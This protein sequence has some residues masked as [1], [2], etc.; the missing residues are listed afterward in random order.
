MCLKNLLLLPLFGALMWVVNGSAV[1][2]AGPPRRPVCPPGFVPVQVI[3]PAGFPVGPGQPGFVPVPV[4]P[5]VGFSA[6]PGQPGL[7]PVPVIPPAGFSIG[8]G[9]L[10]PQEAP[11]YR[12][13]LT[14]YNGP[15]VEQHNYTATDGPVRSA[16]PF[17]NYD[18]FFRDSAQVPWRLYGTYY[19]AWTAEN[20]AGVLRANG[21]QATVRPHC[22]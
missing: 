8:Q 2:H 19:S 1:V 11:P 9:E 6:V 3:P 18:V 10:P 17:T 13:T 15:C 12:H 14:I 20:A 21:N 5:P 22:A 7:V 16:G 4:I